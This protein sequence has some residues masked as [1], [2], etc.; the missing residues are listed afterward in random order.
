MVRAADL[1]A[2][3]TATLGEAWPG[4]R[5]P[6]LPLRPLAPGMALAGPAFTVRCRAGDN[7]ALHRALAVARPGE[8][9]VVDYEASLDSGPFGEIMALAAMARGLAGLVIDG[10]VRD[11][12]QIAA[13][14][15][16]VFARGLDIR[17]T[18]KTDRGQLGAVLRFG[19]ASVGPGD[20][21]VADADAVLILPRDEAGAALAEGRARAGREEEMKRR[22]AAGETTLAILGLM[23]EA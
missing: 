14:G 12:A 11:S 6:G 16:P 7:L 2:L 8:V 23:K 3:G 22:I 19:R 15:F 20:M 10:A 18:T 5:L 1:I 9:L 17:G 13:L 21:V 4:A